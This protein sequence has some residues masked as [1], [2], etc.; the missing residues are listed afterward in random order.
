MSAKERTKTGLDKVGFYCFISD[1]KQKRLRIYQLWF[2]KLF[3]LPIYMTHEYL[4]FNQW[5]LFLQNIF[6]YSILGI[7]HMMNYKVH[8][9]VFVCLSRFLSSSIFLSLCLSLSICLSLCLSMSVW[10]YLS[11]LLC[12][13]LSICICAHVIPK[14]L[15]LFCNYLILLSTK[16]V[17]WRSLREQSAQAFDELIEH[18]EVNLRN[19]ALHS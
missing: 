2:V 3:T 9:S 6:V 18:S 13:C 1:C 10:L 8:L 11:L 19:R 17:S 16:Y 15:R 12:V 5:I 7:F 14:F 4:T